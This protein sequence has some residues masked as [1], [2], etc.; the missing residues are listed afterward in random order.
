LRKGDTVKV[1]TGNEKGK[2]G[3][4]TKIVNDK[5]I[6]FVEK[7]NFVKRHQRPT[8]KGKGGIIEK[9]GP[10]HISNVMLV[11]NKCDNAVRVGCRVLDD[12]NKVRFCKKCNEILDA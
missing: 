11:C 9:E 7:V 8:A 1:I 10:I 2:T 3:K 5:D 4:I 12:G 6:V